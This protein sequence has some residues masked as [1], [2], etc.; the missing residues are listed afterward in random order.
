MAYQKSDFKDTIKDLDGNIIQK[1]TPV[2]AATLGKI[3]DGIVAAEQK[4]DTE[5]GKVATQLAQKAG[6][7]SISSFNGLATALDIRLFST[8]LQVL[9]DSTGNET[10]EWVYKLAL[11]IKEKY[12]T[13]NVNY[14]LWSDALNN[15]GG[16]T[17]INTS[18]DGVTSIG[19]GTQTRIFKTSRQIT[20]D[21]DIG[22]KMKMTDWTPATTVTPIARFISLANERAWYISVMPDG[23]L[24][25]I[26]TPDG[27]TLKLHTSSVVIPFKDGDTGWIR[28]AFDADNGANGCTAKFYTSTDGITWTQL[29]TDITL[30]EIAVINNASDLELGGRT[31]SGEVLP[32]GNLIYES[33]VRDGIDGENIV[34]SMPDLWQDRGNGASH[35]VIGAPTLTIVNGS[36][37][38]SNLT[39]LSESTR[40]VKLTPN[41]GQSVIIVS[42][43]HNEGHVINEEYRNK[44]NAFIDQINT[45]FEGLPIVV[46]AQNPQKSAALTSKPHAMRRVNIYEI[47]RTKNLEVA[48]VY[49]VFPLNNLDPYMLDNIHPNASGQ[50]LWLELIT[51]LWV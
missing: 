16:P 30:A 39:Y 38:G 40:F 6:K 1:G 33:F 21:I 37:P 9:G 11:W 12:P 5:I 17:V 24:R 41:F 28:V 29:G 42:N 48:D 49:S 23:K 14:R 46:I 45:R 43:S 32:S 47:A 27:T 50:D 26:W 36:H 22:V 19:G 25:F 7:K 13:W 3:E 4:I 34:P 44:Y 10:F 8:A 31:Q 18:S 20:G 15:Y 51:S 2:N 35:S